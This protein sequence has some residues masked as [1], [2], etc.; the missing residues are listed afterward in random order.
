MRFHNG[1]DRVALARAGQCAMQ[2]PILHLYLPHHARDL[3]ANFLCLRRIPPGTVRLRH[4]RHAARHRAAHVA[5]HWPRSRHLHHQRP[6]EGRR[7][8][9][10]HQ[11]P[12]SHARGRQLFLL[13]VFALAVHEG[14]DVRPDS[15]VGCDLHGHGRA[16]WGW[17]CSCSRSRV[18]QRLAAR[19][20]PLLSE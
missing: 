13:H 7:Q 19:G 4:Y 17:R 3:S 5:S 6:A 20:E 18:V 9:R 16:G 15:A 11:L 10:P 1:L 2:L 14:D 8:Q 12:R